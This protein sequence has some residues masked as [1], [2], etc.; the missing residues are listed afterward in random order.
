MSKDCKRNDFCVFNK[1]DTYENIKLLDPNNFMAQP[2][3]F[4]GGENSLNPDAKRANG[5]YANTDFADRNLA[6]K[7]GFMKVVATDESLNDWHAQSVG[8]SSEKLTRCY[9]QYANLL[10]NEKNSNANKSLIKKKVENE[11]EDGKKEK[12]KK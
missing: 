1:M 7:K 6:V 4:G 8:L 11:K 9:K 3:P 5:Q 12:K 10:K 2:H